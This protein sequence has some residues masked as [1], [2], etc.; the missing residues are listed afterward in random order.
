MEILFLFILFGYLFY[1]YTSSPKENEPNKFDQWISKKSGKNVNT[2][3]KYKI[4]FKN[5][6]IYIHIHHWLYLLITLIFIK[7]IYIQAFIIGGI[8]QG[9]TNYRDFYKVLRFRKFE[10]I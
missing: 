7:N 1:C 8:I 3:L 6:A 9:I 10:S 2:S 4:I 5:W